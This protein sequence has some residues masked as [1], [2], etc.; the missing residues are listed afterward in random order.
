MPT[1][2]TYP[3]DPTGLLVSN[4]VAGEVKSAAPSEYRNFNFIVPD[5]APFF[6]D[7]LVLRTY[8]GLLPLAEGVDYFLTHK[9]Y[10]ASVSTAE[11]I[12]GSISFFNTNLVG[13]VVMDYQTVGGSWVLS[14]NDQLNMLFNSTINPRTAYWEQLV[15]LPFQFPVVN[16]GLDLNDLRTPEEI[17]IALGNI[18]LA[19]QERNE[20]SNTFATIPEALA[21]TINNRQMSP[22]T[23]ALVVDQAINN[24]VLAQIESTFLLNADAQATVSWDLFGDYLFID[25]NTQSAF[26]LTYS[27]GAYRLAAGVTYIKGIRVSKNTE[28]VLTTPTLPADLWIVV[29]LPDGLDHMTYDVDFVWMAQGAALA[30]SS[31]GRSY[32]SFKMANTTA[33]TVINDFRPTHKRGYGLVFGY[34]NPPAKITAQNTLLEIDKEYILDSSQLG[35]GRLSVIL[36]STVGLLYGQAVDLTRFQG[37]DIE[38]HVNNVASDTIKIETPTG[39][40]QTDTSFLFNINTTVTVTWYGSYWGV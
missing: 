4:L 20:E 32:Y 16:H 9:F 21:G 36:P 23:T 35:G 19:I 24:G 3:F 18:A 2:I 17:S 25:T 22:Y 39:F 33:T 40:Y 7:G 27:T 13:N 29:L 12:Y 5:A 15:N 37:S 28:T 6:K 11:D 26:K 14:T 10:D 34:R 1:L 8:P 38:V 31:G 30:Y